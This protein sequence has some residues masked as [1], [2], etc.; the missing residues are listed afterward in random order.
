M[1]KV[2][3][4]PTCGALP[5]DQVVAIER[6]ELKRFDAPFDDMHSDI[7]IVHQLR[8]S[9]N[10]QDDA[11]KRETGWATTSDRAQLMRRAADTIE[12]LAALPNP[13]SDTRDL[14]IQEEREALELAAQMVESYDGPRCSASRLRS[15]LADEIRALKARFCTTIERDTVD[16]L[17]QKVPTNLMIAAGERVLLQRAENDPEGKWW[18]HAKKVWLAMEAERPANAKTETGWLI[19]KQGPNAL[20]YATATIWTPHPHHALRFARKEDA[21]AFAKAF[22]GPWGDNEVRGWL[23]GYTRIAEHAWG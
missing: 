21:E 18:G 15:V 16:G 22:S 19:E 8:E 7:I 23:E 9:A 20:L 1:D 13:V 4:C 17:R 11:T 12:A 3:S 10:I 14:G 6:A 5:I 2:E